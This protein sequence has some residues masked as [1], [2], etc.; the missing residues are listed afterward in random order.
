MPL[1][2]ADWQAYAI[3]TI[4]LLCLP[5]SLLCSWYIWRIVHRAAPVLAEVTFG[6]GVAL[7]GWYYYRVVLR[8]SSTVSESAQLRPSLL[9][10][11]ML[12]FVFIVAFAVHVKKIDEYMHLQQEFV[13]NVS[14]ELRT[15]LNI[16]MGYA[17]PELADARHFPTIYRA[18]TRMRFLVD[19][20]LGVSRLEEGGA[21][22]KTAVDLADI[23]AE[24]VAGLS[25]QAQRNDIS[26]QTGLEV[27]V[28]YGSEPALVLLVNNLLHNAIKFNRPG[29]NVRISTFAANDGGGVI[30]IND[31]GIGIAADDFPRLFRR[32]EQ[33][34]GSD[35]RNFTGVGIGLYFVDLIV[36]A[37]N[38]RI[39][40]HSQPG[41]GSLFEVWLPGAR[42]DN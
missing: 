13:A 26:L 28:V 41:K 3:A 39:E 35:R 6:V 31:T 10:F 19:N 29:G 42:N 23:A 5:T 1:S 7:F 18:A 11:V 36:Q 17:A 25:I 40:V 15:P 32:F 12:A 30:Q 37:H 20:V 27:A 34:D 14:H 24:S 4:S 8:W 38:G 9:L 2:P 21:L 22:R 33:L 16:I